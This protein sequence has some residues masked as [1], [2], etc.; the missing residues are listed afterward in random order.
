MKKTIALLLA[1]CLTCS[2]SSM[3]LAEETPSGNN[4]T[5]IKRQLGE[6]FLDISDILDSGEDFTE[7][8]QTKNIPT[9]KVSFEITSISKSAIELKSN[10]LIP[11]LNNENT[12]IQT[13]GG[14]ECALTVSD[15][16]TRGTNGY[17]NTLKLNAP[18]SPGTYTI[19]IAPG[20]GLEITSPALTFTIAEDTPE[21]NS[22]PLIIVSAVTLMPDQN[23]IQLM[24]Y[25]PSGENGQHTG[26]PD[27]FTLAKEEVTVTNTETG[28]EYPFDTER[29]MHSNDTYNF[30]CNNPLPTGA[31]QITVQKDGFRF[32]GPSTYPI[33][34]TVD[35]DIPDGNEQVRLVL[36]QVE[37]E[38]LQIVVTSDARAMDYEGAYTLS[39][40]DISVTDITATGADGKT[41]TPNDFSSSGGGYYNVFF[42]PPLPAGQYRLNVKDKVGF[43]V[44][45][46][47]NNP[48][49][50]KPKLV[51]PKIEF[52]QPDA[53]GNVT[54][55]ISVPGMEFQNINLYYM[56]NGGDQQSGY[57][58]LTF[59][60]SATDPDGYLTK[61]IIAFADHND[62]EWS[63]QVKKSYTFTP[64][65]DAFQ[66]VV[67]PISGL[68]GFI[69]TKTLMATLSS[70][71]AKGTVTYEVDTSKYYGSNG[72]FQIEGNK[73]Y[74]EAGYQFDPTDYTLFVKATDN[75]NNP[76]MAS[77]VA[78][79]SAVIH[80]APAGSGGNHGGGSDS[81]DSDSGSSGGGS[82]SGS[83][84]SS[85]TGNAGQL[86]EY[87]VTDAVKDVEEAISVAWGEEIPIG[88]IPVASI[89]LKNTPKL[90]LKV[91]EAINEK[92]KQAEGKITIII[93]S[94]VMKGNAVE[95][96]LYIDPAKATLTTDLNLG[97]SLENKPVTDLFGKY[98]DNEIAIV[99]FE[100]VGTFGMPVNVAVK[101]DLSKL[102]TQTLK[103]YNYNPKTNTYAE[104]TAPAY[105]ID[106]AGYLHFTTTLGNNVLITDKALT[107]K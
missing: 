13:E 23:G 21:D 100:Q 10:V 40:S 54:V 104:M 66:M 2:M 79:G 58:P 76:T 1:V 89:S 75:R 46:I 64:A 60:I 53:S 88:Q 4:E 70:K 103:F 98:F 51:T 24:L 48:F 38:F 71:N 9:L 85:S 52:S 3:A 45:E 62:Y 43:T 55:T 20:E 82:S 41:Y 36:S 22:A 39:K 37:S 57:A 81:D 94:D 67:T 61:E 106:T 30:Y 42:D 69:T 6:G 95:S 78:Y 18:L 96:R 15:D 50:I 19:S 32:T 14:S 92:A 74:S 25:G 12:S 68:K 93:H 102:N 17:W 77:P 80:I 86:V 101:L 33:P 91:I 59:T 27:N 7:N 47:T 8:R 16:G 90:N 35:E 26:I 65:A 44:T 84:N 99:K 31:Y 49:T 105:Y 63:E 11:L 97:V 29:D 34:F 28:T 83:T 56:I 72:G 107:R 87:T 73:V 5:A